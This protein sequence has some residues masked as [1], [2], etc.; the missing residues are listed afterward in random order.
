MAPDAIPN[1]PPIRFFRII[2]IATI[3]TTILITLFRNK[4]GKA[5]QF[6][7]LVIFS[8]LKVLEVLKY[9]P[10][11]YEPELFLSV[12]I[13]SNFLSLFVLI[14]LSVS[15]FRTYI[16]IPYFIVVVLYEFLY[17]QKLKDL[18]VLVLILLLAITFASLIISFLIENEIKQRREIKDLYIEEVDLNRKIVQMKGRLF[19]QERFF[20]L[21]ML[22]AGIAHELGNPVNFLNGNLYFINDYMKIINN[23]IDK[24]T[25]LKADQHKL[26]KINEDFQSIMKHSKTGFE[27]IINIINNMKAVYSN[28]GENKEVIDLKDMLVRTIEFFKASH[29]DYPYTINSELISENRIKIHP[30]EY[31]IVIS[32]VLNNAFEAIRSKDEEGSIYI[33][34]EK[35]DDYI[36]ISISDTGCG[37]RD[38]DLVNIFN[39]FYSTKEGEQNLGLGLALCKDIL[40]ADAGKIK[41]HSSFNEGTT[42]DIYIKENC[43]V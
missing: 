25:L 33:S 8:I 4:Y 12:F 24:T 39:P 19:E 23:M 16:S 27:S 10:K 42:V 5:F 26:T 28:K 22:T 40:E 2:M 21:S 11:V 29:N 17:F 34:T 14:F 13:F 32:N 7:F 43:D 3:C 6:F 31:Y 38:Q 20:S 35:E 36:K 9:L 15:Y 1:Y 30:G 37:I 41:V 18:S